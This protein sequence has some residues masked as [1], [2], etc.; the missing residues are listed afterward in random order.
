MPVHFKLFTGHDS[1]GGVVMVMM[2]KAVAVMVLITPETYA[3]E[4]FS[5]E[6]TILYRGTSKHLLIIRLPLKLTDLR[7]LI[8]EGVDVCLYVHQCVLHVQASLPV[9]RQTGRGGRSYSRLVSVSWAL[10]RGCLRI[11][12][13][14]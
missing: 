10:P 2:R 5:Q 4:T 12:F 1:G 14:M 6:I 7:F 9:K 8:V 11:C 13:G 3:K